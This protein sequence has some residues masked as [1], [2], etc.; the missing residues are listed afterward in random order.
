MHRAS[1]QA[2]FTGGTAEVL[3][4]VLHPSGMSS[5]KLAI[6]LDQLHSVT[7]DIHPFALWV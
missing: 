4:H 3:R 1:Q 7:S 5:Y 2:G 6:Y